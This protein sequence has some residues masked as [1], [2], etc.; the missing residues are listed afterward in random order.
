MIKK[1]L[2]VIKTKKNLFKGITLVRTRPE[3]IKL[4]CVIKKLDKYF[5]HYLIHTGQNYDYNLNEIFFKDLNI[6]S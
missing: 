3:L 1:N 2:I 6:V 5:N 4:S